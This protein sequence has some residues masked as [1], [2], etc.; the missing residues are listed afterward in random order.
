M[1]NQELKITYVPI[2]T[3]RHPEKNPRYWSTEVKLQLKESVA[4]HGIVDPLIINTAPGRENIVVGGNLRLEVL[5]ELGHKT[6]PVVS[7]VITDPDK[8]QELILRLNKN[9]AEFDVTLLSEFDEAFLKDIGFSSEELDEVFE[10]EKNE[11]QFDL[12]KELDKLQIDQITVQKGDV[13]DLDGS[14]LMCGDSTVEADILTLVGNEKVDMCMTDMPYRLSYLKGKTRKG[15]PTVG[16]GAKRNRRYLE[17]EELP[18][19]FVEKWMGN[20]AK[21]AN[22]D[23]SIISYEN[24]RN[25][26]EQWDVIEKQGWKVRNMI[27]WHLPTRNQGYAGKN[28]LFSKHDI[29]MVGTSEAHS[30]L[31]LEP[32]DGLYE[33]QYETALFAIQGK[34]AHWENYGKNKKYCPTDH[35]EFNAADEKSSGQAIIYGVK[36]IEILLPYIKTL[37]K[38][39]QLVI[40][41]FGGSGSTLIAANTL[42]R[43]CF[44]MEKVP[45]YAEVILNR[46]EKFSGKKRV[47]IHAQA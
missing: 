7:L 26:R 28:V 13:Y 24:W 25:I 14:R 41:P 46:W 4:R 27:V 2:E 11:E 36:P 22:K 35:I 5:K 44:L 34:G 16:F 32:E 19:D 40:E 38:R 18:A 23:F 47:K 1:T 42:G 10:I 37:T 33:N 20:V 30:G 29:A 12:E 45:T 31:N 3:L 39:G 8:E 6:V 15:N 43:R 9:V 17:T 21:V